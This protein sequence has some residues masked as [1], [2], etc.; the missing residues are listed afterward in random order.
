MCL[1]SLPLREPSGTMMSEL[2]L[3]LRPVSS[4]EAPSYPCP[5]VQLS[6]SGCPDVSVHCPAAQLLRQDR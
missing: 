1:L 4:T 2:L 3:S 6:M 5:A